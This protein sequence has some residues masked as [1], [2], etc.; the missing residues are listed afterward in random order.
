[1]SS[2][3]LLFLFFLMNCHYLKALLR[4]LVGVAGTALV[5]LVPGTAAT[6]LVALATGLAGLVVTGRA[7][8]ALL[9][10]FLLSAGV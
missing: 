4:L 9:A 3:F 1:M 8:T 10:L 7:A 6:A 5:A 2:I